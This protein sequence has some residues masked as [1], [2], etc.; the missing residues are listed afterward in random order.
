MS[1]PS[2]R[3]R[4]SFKYGINDGVMIERKQPNNSDYSMEI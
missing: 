3:V 4:S 2:L 1:P